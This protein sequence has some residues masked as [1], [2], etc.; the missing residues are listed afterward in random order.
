MRPL[1]SKK[2]LKVLAKAGVDG[3]PA[4][5]LSKRLDVLPATLSLQLSQLTDRG[6]L[7]SRHKGRFIIYSI[8]CEGT[9]NLIASLA[10]IVCSGD[11]NCSHPACRPVGIVGRSSAQGASRANC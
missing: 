8:D 6:L 1:S 7:K 2:V 10:E 5:E 11:G 9:E 3:M 4:G